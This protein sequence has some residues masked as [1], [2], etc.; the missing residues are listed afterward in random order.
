VTSTTDSPRD[1]LIAKNLPYIAV[2]VVALGVTVVR[3]RFGWPAVLLWLAFCALSGAIL[4]FWEA[5]RSALDPESRGDDNDHD[6]RVQAQSELEE[7]KRAAVRALRDVREEHAVGKLSDEDFR[8][9]EARYRGEAR[10]VMQALDDL[11]GDHLARAEAEFDTIAA[12][13]DAAHKTAHPEEPQEA[14]KKVDADAVSA[15]QEP[16][17]TDEPEAKPAAGRDLEKLPP[18]APVAATTITCSSC[19]TVNDSDARFCKKC[20][21]K[22]EGAAS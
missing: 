20:G 14:P 12:E 9:L 13:A 6:L 15:E 11:L 10:T 2:A 19:E 1:E 16:A 18:A 5:L 17:A 3:L 8:E 7:R 22:M 4:L 21:A